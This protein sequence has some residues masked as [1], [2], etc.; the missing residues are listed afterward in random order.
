MPSMAAMFLAPIKLCSS[1]SVLLVIL[2][3]F[4]LD[5][6]TKTVYDRH[7]L[8]KIGSF[9][10]HHKPDFSFLNASALF[11]DNASEPFVWAAWLRPKKHHGERGKRFP[12]DLLSQS[13][14]WLTFSH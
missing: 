2:L 10:T 13:F 6:V 3:F 9:V 5:V 12:S 11:T 8:L 14:F 4:V 1:S 7:M